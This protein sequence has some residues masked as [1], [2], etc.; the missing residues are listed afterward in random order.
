M[1]DTEF[2]FQEQYGCISKGKGSCQLVDTLPESF[3]IDGLWPIAG[4]A[5]NSN[6]LAENLPCI[7]SS[8]RSCNLSGSA[9]SGS[10]R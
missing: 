5:V 2:L 7:R 4:G 1:I 10:I 9:D 3:A 6:L 8:V